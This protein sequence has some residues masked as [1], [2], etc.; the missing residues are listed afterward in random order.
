[1]LKDGGVFWGFTV[2]ARNF[3][4]I[5]SRSIERMG[6]KDRYLERLDRKGAGRYRNYP[7]CYLA[8]KPRA[9]RRMATGFRR[10]EA[11]SFHRVGQLDRVVPPS[12]RPAVRLWDRLTIAAGMPGANL[13]VR[14]E[15]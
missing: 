4:A 3:F 2:D 14:L 15:K 10:C 1:M 5:A 13:V 6:L 9:I 12:L 8:N 7:T 11:R